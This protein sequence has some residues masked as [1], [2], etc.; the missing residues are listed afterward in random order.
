V[1]TILTLS[2]FSDSPRGINAGVTLCKT[3]WKIIREIVSSFIC[4]FKSENSNQ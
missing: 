1:Q 4:Y 3:I 2:I